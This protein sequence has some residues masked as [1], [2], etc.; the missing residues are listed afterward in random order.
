MNILRAQFQNNAMT[1][2][3]R[4]RDRQETGLTQQAR[5]V[6]VAWNYGNETRK[7]ARSG[8]RWLNGRE[9]QRLTRGA[10]K[11]FDLD[12]HTI[13]QVCQALAPFGDV[14]PSQRS[15]AKVAKSMLDAGWSDMKRACKSM[16]NGGGVQAVAGRLSNQTC[17]ECGSLPPSWNRVWP[18]DGQKAVRDSNVN[19]A[20]DV[21]AMGLHKGGAHV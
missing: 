10:S 16:C 8:R 5:A 2:K 18:W 9:L 17:S 14:T 1:Y 7:A 6:N 19:A 15:R 21:R 4:L 20:R 3:F 11:D 13:E 12:T